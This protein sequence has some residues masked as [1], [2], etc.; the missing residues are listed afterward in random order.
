MIEQQRQKQIEQGFEPC[1]ATET[2][3]NGK[4]N[5]CFKCSLYSDCNTMF[6]MTKI[7]QILPTKKKKKAK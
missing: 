1:F 7:E 6:A 3:F 2:V 4:D 5:N